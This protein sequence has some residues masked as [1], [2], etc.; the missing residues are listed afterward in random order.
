MRYIYAEI[1]DNDN[2][3]NYLDTYTHI[4]NPNMILIESYDDKT[5]DPKNNSGTII[6]KK[7]NRETKKLE[8]KS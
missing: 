6:G 5:N 4:D 1:D 8:K 3:K 2:V 7:Y